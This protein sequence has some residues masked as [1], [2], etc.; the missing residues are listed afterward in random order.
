MATDIPPAVSAERF[1]GKQ[2]KIPGC[3]TDGTNTWIPRAWV[4]D[5][6][7]SLEAT[8][9]MCAAATFGLFTFEQICI[10]PDPVDV[11]ASALAELIDAGYV[12][13]VQP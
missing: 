9:V 6:S 11:T 13:E 1:A 4:Q 8:G 10:G 2:F 12:L 5:Q 3:F 7:V